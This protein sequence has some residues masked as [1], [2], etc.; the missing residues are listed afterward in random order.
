MSVSE[1]K[2]RP[3]YEALDSRNAKVRRL[4][5]ERK[6]YKALFWSSVDAGAMSI[7]RM[8]TALKLIN[9]ALPKHKDSQ[10]LRVLKGLALIRL[11]RADEAYKAGTHPQPPCIHSLAQW[12][13][14]WP[15][16]TMMPPI[17]PLVIFHKLCACE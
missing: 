9:A 3:I 17:C 7:L 10:L 1:R 2:L 4:Q 14:L 6:A 16:C 15:F 12:Q 11:D 8:Q 5:Y 13:C